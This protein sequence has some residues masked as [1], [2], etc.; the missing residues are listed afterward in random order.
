LPRRG[1]VYSPHRQ[2]KIELSNLQ[3]QTIFDERDA[4]EQTPKA[5]SAFE[6]LSR[7]NS[8]ISLEPVVTEVKP[9]NIERLLSR[10]TTCADG[11]DNRKSGI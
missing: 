6:H 8:D 1:R 10:R 5:I 11:T 2:G 9:A 7:V 3:R 4:R